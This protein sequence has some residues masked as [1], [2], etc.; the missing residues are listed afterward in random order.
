MTPGGTS[1]HEPPP[2]PSTRPSAPR[3]HRRPTPHP[4]PRARAIAK[5]CCPHPC[6]AGRRAAHSDQRSGPERRQQRGG[7]RRPPPQAHPVPARVGGRAGEPRRS[8][9]PPSSNDHQ[10]PPPRPLQIGAPAAAHGVAAMTTNGPTSG[11]NDERRREVVGSLRLTV[12]RAPDRVRQRRET[13]IRSA[14]SKPSLLRG[15]SIEVRVRRKITGQPCR[16][17]NSRTP[18]RGERPRPSGATTPVARQRESHTRRE[19]MILPRACVDV[20]VDLK[21]PRA[22]HSISPRGPTRVA[23]LAR[24]RVPPAEVVPARRER[25]RPD[26][27]A[28][29]SSDGRYIRH[30]HDGGQDRARRVVVA[31]CPSRSSTAGSWRTYTHVGSLTNHNVRVRS[32]PQLPRTSRR[33]APRDRHGP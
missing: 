15:E 16:H 4:R 23:R 10:A 1:L 8:S 5:H 14:Q 28:T 18:Y 32:R 26:A 9:T 29:R 30:L 21:R 13:T 6:R 33:R 2:S 19:Q 24:L 25:S 27:A 17:R 3:G 31:E 20:A 12:S 7:G 22:R 11:S